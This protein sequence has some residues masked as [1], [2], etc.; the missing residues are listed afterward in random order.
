MQDAP[1][2]TSKAAFVLGVREHKKIPMLDGFHGEC[3]SN[4]KTGWLSLVDCL[5]IVN[6]RSVH[7]E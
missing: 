7:I 6:L 4:T 1:L 5:G 2:D 3:C